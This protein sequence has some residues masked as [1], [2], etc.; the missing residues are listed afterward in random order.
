MGH[1]LVRDLFGSRIDRAVDPPAFE[2]HVDVAG[3]W[4]RKCGKLPAS[5]RVLFWGHPAIR[6]RDA[7]SKEGSDETENGAGR[8]LLL[9]FGRPTCE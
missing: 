5:R 9:D 8:A 4:P 1:D 6:G 3:P 2:P 7:A